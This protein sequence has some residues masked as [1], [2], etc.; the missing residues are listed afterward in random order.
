MMRNCKVDRR[1]SEQ[2]QTGGNE[3]DQGDKFDPKTD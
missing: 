1:A 2:K 3:R